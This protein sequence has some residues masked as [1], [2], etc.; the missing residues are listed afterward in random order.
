M[1]TTVAAVLT[2]AATYSYFLIFAQFSFIKLAAAVDGTGGF[3]KPLMAVMGLAGMAGS[4]LAAGV[5]QA[6]RSRLLLAMGFVVC[7]AAAGSALAARSI[8][9]FYGSALLVGLGTG[10]ATVTLASVLRPVLGR[11]RLGRV[12]G[13]GTGLAYGMCNLPAIFQAAATTQAGLAVALAGVGLVATFGLTVGAA[14]PMPMGGDYSKSGVVAWVMIFLALVGLDSAAFFVI[15]HTPVLLELTWS[16]AGRLE[17]NAGIHFFAAVL[18]GCALDRRRVGWT[19]A[20]GALA[21]LAACGLIAGG[22]ITFP[23]TGLLYA[24]GVSIYSTV[25]VYYPADGLRPWLAGL[26][27]V[28]AGWGGSAFGIGM[29]AG[30]QVLPNGLLLIAGGMMLSGLL[31]R[32]L[33]GGRFGSGNA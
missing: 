23:G 11:G 5:Y 26:V 33:R 2:V 21:L 19:V 1:K 16:G 29:V 14:A 25:L 9:F 30:R 17:A 13:A 24:A 20:L 12:I 31:L 10:F 4:A 27:Y 3:I 18:A 32:G 7:A 15:Q 22:H 28:V 6:R 8:G